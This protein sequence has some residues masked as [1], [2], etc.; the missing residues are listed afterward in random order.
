MPTPLDEFEERVLALNGLLHARDSVYKVLILP[1]DK[2]AFTARIE[3]RIWKQTEA[4]RK[5]LR[6]DK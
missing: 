6:N 1:E 2:S 5:L 3:L 4:L